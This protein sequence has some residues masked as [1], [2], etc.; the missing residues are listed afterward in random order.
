M[1]GQ[2]SPSWFITATRRRTGYSSMRIS[3]AERTEAAD[4]LSK[5]YGDGRLDE[6]E[7]HQRLDQAMRAK[8]YADL[9]G[10]FDDLPRTEAE[11]AEAPRTP[12]RRHQEHPHRVGGLVLVVALVIAAAVVAGHAM[13][14]FATGFFATFWIWLALIGVVLFALESRRKR[15]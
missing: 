14:W 7:F 10:L 9:S 11:A 1:S 3:D 13:A 5:H 2:A 15:S 6:A 8:T 4:L 12:A